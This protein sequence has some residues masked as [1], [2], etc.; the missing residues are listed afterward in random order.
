MGFGFGG[1][2]CGRHG[3]SWCIIIIIIILL[4]SCCNDD[5]SSTC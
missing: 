4:L 1:G 3:N 5:C 2:S